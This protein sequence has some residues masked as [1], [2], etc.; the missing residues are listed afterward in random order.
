L[1][2]Y[3]VE[4]IEARCEGRSWLMRTPGASPF[5]LT[6]KRI[7]FLKDPRPGRTV[8]IMLADW[9]ALGFRGLVGD[10]AYEANRKRLR[11]KR[12]AGNP[13]TAD[14]RFR[15][16]R[17]NLGLLELVEKKF[18]V[19]NDPEREALLAKV[20]SARHMRGIW[21]GR[22]WHGRV[23]TRLTDDETEMVVAGKWRDCGPTASE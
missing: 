12:A 17:G 9:Y 20:V 19:P 23:V 15:Q 1:Q 13:P 16:S 5:T 14:R 22:D 18:T 2:K 10:A 11:A 21:W 8:E 3:T 6:T 7:I 4:L